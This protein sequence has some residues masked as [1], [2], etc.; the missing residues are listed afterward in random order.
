MKKAL[1]SLLI[2]FSFIL[3]VHGQ[4]I[5]VGE[6]INRCVSLLDRP[7][8]SGFRHVGAGGSPDTQVY[9]SDE[10][11]LLLVHNE[12]VMVS[13]LVNTFQSAS[14]ANEYITLFST[15]LRN[16]SEWTFFRTSSRGAEIFVRNGLC[17]IIER[18]RRLN[19]NYDRV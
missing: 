4:N 14:E 1:I 12:S 15:Y 19:R 8:P 11:I 18:P 6:L 2:F 3:Q 7:V 9:Y 13:N 17:A 10:R 5:N 16:N